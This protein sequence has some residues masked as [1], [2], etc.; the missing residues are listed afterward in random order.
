MYI[1]FCHSI[2]YVTEFM[3]YLS[4]FQYVPPVVQETAIL[5][6]QPT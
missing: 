1:I 4:V 5:L 3:R 6:D 2:Y